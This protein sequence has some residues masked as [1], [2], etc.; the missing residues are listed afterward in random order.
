VGHSERTNR[1]SIQ[2]LVRSLARRE[3]APRW[4][5]L[6]E[7]PR[8]RAYMHLDTVVTPVDGN[9]ALVYPPVLLSERH[10]QE[11]VDAAATRGDETIDHAFRRGLQLG[12]A[13]I[14]AAAVAV[15]VVRV[16]ARRLPRKAA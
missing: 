9:A 2:G 4:L 10:Q 3:G 6:V 13:L 5:I 1:T 7:L 16:A 14:A 8:R 15:L 12:L 11:M